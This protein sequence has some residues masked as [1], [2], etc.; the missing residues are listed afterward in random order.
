V[1]HTKT[2]TA[3]HWLTFTFQKRHI[4]ILLDK[5]LFL[6][7]LRHLHGRFWGV[8]GVAIMGAGFGVCFVIRPDLL[9]ISTAFSNFANDVRTAPYFA[10]SVF[11]AAYGLWR[12]QRYLARTW[13]RAMPVTGLISLTVI[14]LYLVA[15]M[16]ISWG[17]VP[18]AIHMFGVALAYGSMLATVIMDGLLT[19]TSLR[20]GVRGWRLVRFVSIVLIILGG[21]L[22]LGSARVVGWFHLSLL[23]EISLLAGYFSWI[24]L[25]TYVGEGNRTI[26]SRILRKLVLID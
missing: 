20:S 12:W 7:F 6:R 24:V 15:L 18:Y 3:G 16:P 25:K 5:V 11:V 17:H 2:K 21:W 8:A 19:R 9:H 4:H 1:R 26:L 10:A 22:T 13:K 23:G 14:G